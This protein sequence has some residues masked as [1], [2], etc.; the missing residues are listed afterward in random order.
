LRTVLQTFE[1]CV[2]FGGP[3]GRKAIDH[4]G[5]VARTLD[6]TALSQVSEV[7]GN[8]GLGKPQNLL[9]VAHTQGT[10][11]EQM[12]DPKPRRLTEALVDANQLH[13]QNHC[14]IRFHASNVIYALKYICI[15]A[16]YPRRRR[17][18]RGGDGSGILQDPR[19]ALESL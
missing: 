17:K 1:I 16:C 19:L 2:E 5:L 9:K 6:Q 10:L 7:L 13:E 15:G 11:S 14:L 18:I 4:P 12:K 3:P 8:L